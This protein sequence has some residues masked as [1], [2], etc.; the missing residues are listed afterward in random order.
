[1]ERVAVQL[2]GTRAAWL[3]LQ[4]CSGDQAASRSPG[5]GAAWISQLDEAERRAEAF[6]TEADLLTMA[7]EAASG[8]R[9]LQVINLCGRQRML[10]Q[11]LAKQ[12]L[13][14]AV[15]PDAAAAAQTAAAV[16]TVQAFEA[17]LLALEQAPL[18]S[19]GIRAA[20]AQAR[21]QWHRLLDGQRRAGGGDAVAGR[22][23]LARE[24]DA[25]SNSFDQLTSLY[26]HSMQVLLG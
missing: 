23:A 2:A 15:L 20:L 16:L 25:L 12:A 17:A 13:L 11:R 19:E 14:A 1:A 26:E 4:A 24:S 5:G 18:A 3:A 7:L 10:S 8:R 9:N 22:S 21:G 6:L